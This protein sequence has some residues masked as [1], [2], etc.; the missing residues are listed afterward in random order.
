MHVHRQVTQKFTH[1]D[2]F[3]P[4]PMAFIVLL[5]RNFSCKRGVIIL[6]LWSLVMLRPTTSRTLATTLLFVHRM[7]LGASGCHKSYCNPCAR[8]RISTTEYSS[9]R[10]SF[11]RRI[12]YTTVL[13]HLRSLIKHLRISLAGFLAT[14]ASFSRRFT[15]DGRDLGRPASYSNGSSPPS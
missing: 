11:T 10:R 14:E 7:I 8:S 3:T 5:L 1:N 6:Q 12:H 15:I 2:R 9:K 13:F 4:K